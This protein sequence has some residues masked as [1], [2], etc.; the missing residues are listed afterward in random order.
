MRSSF[1]DVESE[2]RLLGNIVNGGKGEVGDG[3]D[4]RGF[5]SLKRADRHARATWGRCESIE[6]DGAKCHTSEELQGVCC[7]SSYLPSA[8]RCG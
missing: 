4:T 1:D 6:L 3:V 8:G 5:T 2:C 7:P